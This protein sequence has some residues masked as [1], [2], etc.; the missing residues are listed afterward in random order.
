MKIIVWE[1]PGFSVNTIDILFDIAP[2]AQEWQILRELSMLMVAEG[3]LHRPFSTLSNGE[4]TKVLLAGLFLR[5][6]S[7]LLIDEACKIDRAAAA[8][9]H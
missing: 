3:V 6:N 1:F 9:C 8:G 2:D 7:F 5:P 4:Q